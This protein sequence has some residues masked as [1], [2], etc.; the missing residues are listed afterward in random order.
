MVTRVSFFFLHK[1][2]TEQNLYLKSPIV[3][4][5]LQQ[6]DIFKREMNKSF[7][8]GLGNLENFDW[9]SGVTRTDLACFGDA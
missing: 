3:R 6:C 9:T 2:K 1:N 4:S 5:V 7:M 8:S